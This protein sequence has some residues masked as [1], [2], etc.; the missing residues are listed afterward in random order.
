MPPL[1][2]RHVTHALLLAAALLWTGPAAAQSDAEG[3]EA[4]A[5]GD[6]ASIDAARAA[7]RPPAVT[8]VIVDGVGVADPLTEG[9]PDPARGRSVFESPERGNCVACHRLGDVGGGAGPALDGVGVRLTAGALRLWIVNPRALVETEDKPAYFS[10]FDPPPNAPAP[11][12]RLTAQEIE[13]VVAYLTA[14][15]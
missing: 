14:Q 12:T 9:E 8:Y 6:P 11:V 3:V 5:A 2:A 10:V 4:P 13:D 15:R 1:R 7:A